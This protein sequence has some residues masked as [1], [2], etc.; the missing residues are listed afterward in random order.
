MF[1]LDRS[2]KRKMCAY[3]RDIKGKCRTR[4]KLQK[5]EKKGRCK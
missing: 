1:P 3:E 2:S 5:S 4:E